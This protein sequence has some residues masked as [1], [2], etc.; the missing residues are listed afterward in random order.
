MKRDHDKQLSKL[1]NLHHAGM[2]MLELGRNRKLWDELAKRHG[3]PYNRLTLAKQFATQYS[4]RDLAELLCLRKPDGTPLDTDYVPWLLTLPWHSERQRWMRSA[5]QNEIAQKGWTAREVRDE[6]KRRNLDIPP[7]LVRHIF[8]D[9]LR[10]FIGYAEA[11]G[12]CSPYSAEV[13]AMAI[14]LRNL[15]RQDQDGWTHTA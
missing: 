7:N 8:I 13:V 3:I 12:A 14:K 10:D 11:A 1:E 4:V 5:F 9:Q 6:I 15:V 2:E